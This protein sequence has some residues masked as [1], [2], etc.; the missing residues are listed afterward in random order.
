MTESEAIETVMALPHA[1]RAVLAERL[2]ESLDHEHDFEVHPR[3]IEEANRLAAEVKAGR[4]KTI[5]WD[6]AMQSIRE[7]LS[8]DD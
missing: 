1:Q 8:R 7:E 5:P 3:W 2:L 4:A 6:E